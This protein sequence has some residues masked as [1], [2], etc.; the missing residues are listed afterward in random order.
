V[1]SHLN[2]MQMGSQSDSGSSVLPAQAA[3]R[4]LAE[5]RLVQRIFDECGAA[6]EQACAHTALP[7]EFL[8]ALVANESGGRAGASRFEP[9]VYRH[10]LAVARGE[11]R[12]YG[13]LTAADLDAEAAELLPPD[14]TP[15]HAR[16]LNQDFTERHAPQL[17]GCPDEV[18]RQLATSWGYTQIMGYHM[19]GRA[20]TVRDLL[21]APFH[22]RVAREL[23]SEFAAAYR[24]DLARAFSELFCCWNTGRPH[25]KT[26]DPNYVE[27]G[28]RR[29][30]ICRQLPAF[31]AAR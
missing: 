27:N 12:A 10:L 3:A 23:L 7:V 15:L 26:F 14:D 28:L 30:W 25:G 29:M 22:F 11:R 17:Q 13:S 2:P 24:L 1:Q 18:L 9:G 4:E 20:G 16:F 6:I 21:A 5:R 8:V 19:A 31:V